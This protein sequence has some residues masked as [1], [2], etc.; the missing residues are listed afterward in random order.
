MRRSGSVEKAQSEVSDSYVFVD[1]RK[2]SQ[3]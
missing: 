1:D 3:S 2:K